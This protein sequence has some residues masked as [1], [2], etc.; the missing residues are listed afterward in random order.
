MMTRGLVLMAVAL[1][2]AAG[3]PASAQHPPGA[4]DPAPASKPAPAE[5]RSL[6]PIVFFVARGEPNACGV[7][8]REW[9]VAEGSIDKGA[10]DRLRALLQRLGKRKLPIFFHSPG[11]SV[12]AGLAIGRLIRQRGL[13]AGLG[14]TVPA[15]CDP[16]Q[17]REPACDKLKRAGR[18]L[19]AVLDTR[20]TMCNSS[21]VFAFVGGAV[22]EAGPQAVLGVH[23]ISF[24]LRH[25]DADGR[26]TRTPSPLTPAAER[27]ALEEWYGKIGAYLREMGISQDLLA[28]ARAVENERLRYLTREQIVA[29]GIDRRQ[30]VESSWWFIDRSSGP[31]A[32]KVIEENRGGTFRRD[33]LR[34]TCRGPT[35]LRLQYTRELAEGSDRPPARLRVT[36]SA[37]S[38]LFG[39]P[40]SSNPNGSRGPTEVRFADVPLS[41]LGETAFTIEA[42]GDLGG[43]APGSAASFTP[44]V[45]RSA[46]PGL[47]DL[48]RR[49]PA[50]VSPAV[51]SE[52]SDHLGGRA[53]V[54]RM[55]PKA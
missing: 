19:V 35:S 26:V 21:C 50:D 15:G 44:V 25:V 41:L 13:T 45:V 37:G 2:I 34:L 1:G 40:T 11:G 48:S 3:T 8:C 47:G 46:G 22:R 14:W 6:P 31:S 36:A 33:T 42:A 38:V 4:G 43:S 12:A 17:R 49:C 7:G 23:S 9:I 10:D 55:E 30:A 16:K 27:K 53:S 28:A 20:Y 52:P 18:D 5:P 32:D 54:A 39:S 51:P 24:A 29:F